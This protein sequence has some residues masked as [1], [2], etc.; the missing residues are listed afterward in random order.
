MALDREAVSKGYG[1]Y[2][3]RIGKDDNDTT[4]PGKRIV[5]ASDVKERP[6]LF[7]EIAQK[8]A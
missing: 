8:N 5:Y 4:F 7:M 1:V 6:R 2:V 3:I